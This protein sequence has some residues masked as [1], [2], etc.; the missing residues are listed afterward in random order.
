MAYKLNDWTLSDTENVTPKIGDDFGASEYV[1][2]DVADLSVSPYT[3]LTQVAGSTDKGN[4]VEIVADLS[5]EDSGSYLTMYIDD[6]TNRQGIKIYNGKVA[7][8]DGSSETIIE[9]EAETLHRYTITMKDGHFEFLFDKE[10]LIETDTVAESQL[11]GLFIGFGEGQSGSFVAKFK[12]IKYAH[13]I[14]KY[15]VLENVDFDL[16]IDSAPTFDSVNLHT[17]TKASF[18]QTPTLDED[19]KPIYESW[20]PVSYMCGNYVGDSEYGVSSY[21]GKGLVTAVTIKLPQ[22]A[23]M[24]DPIFYYRVRFNGDY[25]SDF[26]TVYSNYSADN[27]DT[28]SGSSVEYDPSQSQP[29]EFPEGVSVYDFTTGKYSDTSIEFTEE[30]KGTHRIVAAE[31]GMVVFIPTTASDNW[32]ISFQNDGEYAIEV[33]TEAGAHLYTVEPHTVV[34]FQ[35]DTDLSRYHIFV[36][37]LQASFR[38]RP[39]ISS[40]VFKA[41]Y[42]AHLP[43][44]LDDVY[45]KSYETGV[46][47]TLIRAEAREIADIITTF[48]DDSDR[49]N[50]FTAPNDLFTQRWGDIFNFDKS[51]FKNQA[52]M[53][54]TLQCIISKMHGEMMYQYMYDIISAITGAHPDIINYKDKLFNVVWTTETSKVVPNSLKFYLYDDEHPSFEINPFVL[55]GGDAQ[56][57]TFEINIY[58]PFDLQYNR[59]MIKQVIELFKPGWTR[60]VITFYDAEGHAYQDKYYYGIH[61]YGE[62]AYN[63]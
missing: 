14:Y 8:L 1:I 9:N 23:G 2:F 34:S 35:F 53:R 56:A 50:I 38:L 21:D 33:K 13:T 43:A 60:A 39:D 61:N 63:N 17:Y 49:L 27:T 20:D 5:D 7:L 6:G 19:G 16:Q 52:E 11:P 41:V 51:I 36:E 31:D 40:E 37:Q 4:S 10:C 24:Q 18:Q 59:D 44:D 22:K 62:A 55:Y 25:V 28:I 57:Y 48:Q 12:Y 46:A 47:A 42:Y 58:D 29:F 30:D 45:T 15:I 26:A 54:D 32:R 3:N